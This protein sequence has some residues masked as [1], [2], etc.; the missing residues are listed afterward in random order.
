MRR[1]RKPRKRLAPLL[2][3]L[4]AS[5]LCCCGQ[6]PASD[7]S[8]SVIGLYSPAKGD[9]VVARVQG[10]PIYAA[11]LRRELRAGRDRDQALKELIRREVLVIEALKRGHLSGPEVQRERRSALAE[12]LIHRAFGAKF[13]KADIPSSMVARSFEL[14]K[15]RFQHPELVDVSHILAL[16]RKGMD[17]ALKERARITAQEVHRLATATKSLSAAAFKAIAGQLRANAAPIELRVERLRTPLR[18]YTVPAFADPAFALKAK[19]EISPV[20]HTRFGYHVIYLHERSPAVHKKLADVDHEIREKIFDEARQLS[21]ERFAKGL[22]KAHGVIV[23]EDA[24][25]Q[26]LAKGE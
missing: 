6:D 16:W 23:D 15:R 22:E 4:P 14:N 7:Q 11:D 13:T 24:L 1:H 8:K 25:R 19:G 18:G 5:L 26:S 2:C 20:V 3:L 21:F 17:P 12:T 9:A 10:R